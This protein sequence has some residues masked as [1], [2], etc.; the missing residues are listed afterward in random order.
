MPGSYREQGMTMLQ[1]LRENPMIAASIALPL[2]VVVFFLL[3][4]ALP[5]W[6][7][8]PPGYSFLFT[9]P[10]HTQRS[11]AIDVRFDVVDGRLRVRVYNAEDYYRST[12]RLYLFD[13]ETLAAREIHFD[14]PANVDSFEDGDEIDVPGFG[15]SRILTERTAPDGYEIRGS[16]Y[17]GDNLVTALFGG[18]G[19]RSLSVH[20]SG[21]VFD[22]PN[23]EINNYYYNVNF[24]GWLAN[25]NER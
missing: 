12:P 13:H 15:D 25:A 3:A 11:P 19:H 22:I 4:S 23:P 8:E 16:D 1:R 18:H 9:V 21:A 2:L 24:L 5:K 17:R 7:V 6:L 20:K 14:L 10:D